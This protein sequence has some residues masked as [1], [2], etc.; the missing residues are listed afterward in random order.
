MARDIADRAQSRLSD[1]ADALGDDVGRGEDLVGLLVEQ[2]VVVAEM[3][4]AD[5]PVEILGLEVERKGVG[6][7]AVDGT[8]NVL[9]GIGAQIGRSRKAR[10]GAAEVTLFM[11]DFLVTIR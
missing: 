10:R 11:E 7:D 6:Q 5:V 8:G 9:G 1:F 3:R 2:Q 4:A